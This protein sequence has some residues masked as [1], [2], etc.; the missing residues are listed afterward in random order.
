[1]TPRMTLALREIALSPQVLQCLQQLQLGDCDEINSFD[2]HQHAPASGKRKAS[3]T[4]GESAWVDPQR[5][6][7]A[8]GGG[9]LA[10]VGIWIH[11]LSR[12]ACGPASLH[13]R[14]HARCMGGHAAPP[15]LQEKRVGRSGTSQV[16]RS[17][18]F[19]KRRCILDSCLDFQFMSPRC[20]SK[21]RRHRM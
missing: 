9:R 16:A 11:R 3:Q 5:R 17:D 12:F 6:Q 1:M 2:G 7:C 19:G 21:H 18:F 15:Q 13:S 20:T 8:S 4:H 10:P 14:E